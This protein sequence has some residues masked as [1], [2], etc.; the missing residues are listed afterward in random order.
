MFDLLGTSSA[1]KNLITYETDHI[2]PRKD[3]IKESL[4]WLDKYFGT[5]K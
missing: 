3:F 5:V 4:A 2:I 1:D